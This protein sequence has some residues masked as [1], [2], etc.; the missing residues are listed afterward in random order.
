MKQAIPLALVF[1][2]LVLLAMSPVVAGQPGT[3]PHK[4]F[5][6]DLV[7]MLVGHWS[8]TGTA[9]G[10][11]VEQRCVGEWALSHRFLR[12]HCLNGGEGEAGAPVDRVDA[13]IGS[14]EDEA[15]PEYEVHLKGGFGAWSCTTLGRGT[16][17]ENEILLRFHCGNVPLRVTLRWDRDQ[18]VWL[19]SVAHQDLAGSWTPV[20]EQ[21]LKPAE[22]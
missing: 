19:L 18:H 3:Q 22:P 1:G 15:A 8:L 17:N 4:T 10:Q 14:Y 9:M 5:H 11:R 7:K 21:K 12:L 13:Y 6:D 20:A 2:A 16:R